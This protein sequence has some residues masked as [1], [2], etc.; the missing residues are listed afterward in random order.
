MSFWGYSGQAQRPLFLG[1]GPNELYRRLFD[2]AQEAY[3]R[4]ARVLR[5]GATS[6]DV[7]D[8]ADVIHERGFAVNDEF[9]HGFGIGLLPPGIAT[10]Q[11]QRGPPRPRFTFESGMCVVL[12]PNVVTRDERSGVQLGNLLRITETGTECLHRLPLQYYVSG[13]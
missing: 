12:Q 10:R 1:E 8:A 4:C 5:A 2:C 7:L 3:T 13:S 6:D 11:A 9:L